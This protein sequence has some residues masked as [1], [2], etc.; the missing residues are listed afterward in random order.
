MVVLQDALAATGPYLQQC[1]ELDMRY[2]I[3]VQPGS[4]AYLFD[5]IGAG[6]AGEWFADDSEAGP[7][8][9]RQLRLVSDVPLNHTHRD[10][11][12]V[13]VLQARETPPKGRTAGRARTWTWVTDLPLTRATAAEAHACARSRWKIE[14]EIFNTLKNQGYELEHN[15]GH[16]HQHLATVL[17][18]L[19]LLAFLIDQLQALCCPLFQAALAKAGPRYALWERLRSH[20]TLMPF[21]GWREFYLF[22]ERP[23][24]SHFVIPAF[25]TS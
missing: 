4:H 15:F 10:T 8:C 19:M 7:A 9:D 3:A 1:R 16:G 20:L 24:S 11:V 13:T 22:T 25:D 6:A 23:S 2:L 5:E 12:R 21:P 14:N 17:M 18:L